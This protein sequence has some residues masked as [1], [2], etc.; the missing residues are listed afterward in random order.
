M[1]TRAE[2]EGGA[3]HVNEER[4]GDSQQSKQ[5]PL[6]EGTAS[7]QPESTQGMMCGSQMRILGVLGEASIRAQSLGSLQSHQHARNAHQ[8]PMGAAI[9]AANFGPG[10]PSGSSETLASSQQARISRAPV[11]R[12]DPQPRFLRRDPPPTPDSHHGACYSTCR[13]VVRQEGG[14][15]RHRIARLG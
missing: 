15:L 12:R 2:R 5:E 3:C 1:T 6:D 7:R 14:C 8:E 4:R 13:Y 10:G 11:E 9:I